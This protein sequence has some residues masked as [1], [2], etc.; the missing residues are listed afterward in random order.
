[1]YLITVTGHRPPKLG[2]GYG[3]TERNRE[4]V[5][6]MVSQLKEEVDRH[7]KVGVITGM[8][9]GIDQLFAQAALA[10]Q[11]PFTAAVPFPGQESRWPKRGQDEYRE[12]LSFA[13][14][15]ITVTPR[16]SPGAFQE[17]NVW[18]VNHADEVWA[19]WDGSPGGTANCVRYAEKVNVEVR[20]MI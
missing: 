10:L 11:I 18:M 8:A 2:L 20:R 13:H 9:L 17:R 15:V 5:E 3:D 14:K 4:V 19:Y 1:M 12:L 16:Y 6:L 7:Y